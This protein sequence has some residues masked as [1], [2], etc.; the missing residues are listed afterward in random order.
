M[1][2]LA[3]KDLP[4][5]D[6]E[7]YDYALP[8]DRIAK[9]PLP[10][11]ESK[12]LIY[13]EGP[14]LS[15]S[16]YK[17]ID[18]ALPENAWLIFNETKVVQARLLFPKNEHSIIEVFCLEPS[19]GM[20]IEQAMQQENEIEYDCLVGGARK[21]KEGQ[22]LEM[23]L[24]GFTLRAQKVSREASHFKI[25]L[26]WNQELNFGELL[27]IAG[28][29][30]LPPYIKRAAEAEDK[31]TY[32][33]VY[34]SRAGSVAAPTAGLHFNEAI[35]DKLKARKIPHSFLTL[36]VGAGTFKPVST[37]VHEHEMHAEE[38]FADRAFVVTLLEKLAAG[39][40]IIP[41]GTTS[42][43]ALESLY[44]LGCMA[45]DD[46]I[47][48]LK[49]V[50]IPQWIGFDA[51]VDALSPAE[52][53]QALLDF[54]DRSKQSWYPFKTQLIIAPGYQHRIIKGLVT[55][56]HQPKSTLMLLVASLLGDN[57]KILYN[58]ALQNDFRFLSY[59]DGCL[60]LPSL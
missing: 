16:H 19:Y 35:F 2:K 27:E 3:K 14:A 15:E 7:Q 26:S 8:E 60:L 4:S 18:Q 1:S 44:W 13:K 32:Q 24:A 6:I 59:G 25:K 51:S 21:W 33:T 22:V 48:E 47:G 23:P 49:E 20:S 43:R 55:N 9:Y 52:A 50:V 34:A 37:S 29:T 10:R 12:L 38:L 40:A 17:H 56:F 39:R 58:Y 54:L 31:T 36:H 41:V 53:F 5:L 57:W 11:G 28:K 30:P 42:L 45:K 46:K